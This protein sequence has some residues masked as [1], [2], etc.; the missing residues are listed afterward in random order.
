MLQCIYLSH[1]ISHLRLIRGSTMHQVHQETSP[2][3]LRQRYRDELSMFDPTFVRRH[4]ELEEHPIDRED[5]CRLCHWYP[6]TVNLLPWVGTIRS[7]ELALAMKGE[8]CRKLARSCSKK[9]V[10]RTLGKSTSFLW[11]AG[12]N[13]VVWSTTKFDQLANVI[14]Q[15]TPSHCQSTIVCSTPSKEFWYS[16]SLNFK[17]SFF[18][19]HPLA[20]SLDLVRSA[21]TQISMYKLIY[22]GS[23]HPTSPQ[24]TKALSLLRSSLSGPYPPGNPNGPSLQFNLS[25]VEAP[26]N[27]DQLKTILSYLP[28]PATKPSMVLLSA[29]PTTSGTEPPTLRGI[30]E[31]AEKNP[32]TL[33]WPIVV[34]W[35]NGKAAIGS[36]EGARDILETIRKRRDGELKDEETY[37][38]KGCFSWISYRSNRNTFSSRFDVLIA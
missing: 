27:A 10:G 11:W 2:F 4:P 5:R 16:G 13:K 6:R 9:W 28:Y 3:L 30:V 25:V 37:L 29:H 32:K 12:R 38:P 23:H 17:G 7:Q 20:R 22:S 15:E 31:L 34:D 8:R 18:S 1:L 21:S 24:S 19:L 33:N 14:L 35:K 26:P 36:V